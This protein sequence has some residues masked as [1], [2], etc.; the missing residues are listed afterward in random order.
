MKPATSRTWSAFILHRAAATLAGII[1]LAG[2]G[3]AR[4]HS[5]VQEYFVPMPEAQIR[6]SFLT[7][8]PATGTTMDSVISMVVGSA[9]SVVVYDHWEDGYEVDLGNPTQSST[10]VW[11]DGNPGND[12]AI[13]PCGGSDICAAGTVIALRNNVTLPRNPATVLYD[14]R[15]RV[16]ATK[17]VV[18][19]RS[20]WATS[21]GSVLADAVE[22]NATIDWGTNFVMPIGQDVIFPTPATSSMF[23]LVSMFVLAAE[24]GT[25]ITIDSDANG[26]PNYTLTLNQ[27]E[28]YY[29]PN[30][31]LKSATVVA[32]KPVEVHL[33]TGDIG[34]NYES[35]WFTIPPTDQWGPIYYSPVGT[36]SDGDD[37]YIFL[38]NPDPGAITVNYQTRVSSGSFPIPAK[39]TYRFLLPQDS[40]AKFFSNGNK[41][42]FAV[43]TVG[44][45]PTAN[46]VHDWGFSLVPEGNL[47][48][49]VIVGWGPGSSDLSQ[50]GSPV[51]VTPVADT[52]VYVDYNG[53]KNGPLTDPT[54]VK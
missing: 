53:D 23:E 3:A 11:G 46:N 34:A 10:Q 33:L 15:D 31:I 50:N 44:A 47:T 28:S 7:L 14:G 1:L 45:E 22:V 19:S 48:T 13:H 26:A 29:V 24:N 5:L 40:G 36:A 25:L 54:G 43:G 41:P 51:W 32:T 21:P 9:N 6:S 4:A 2:A 12:G 20:A 16:G 17:A 38:Y 8:A 27:G 39:D 30:G 35:R 42:F 37:S 52:R 49:M 18:M